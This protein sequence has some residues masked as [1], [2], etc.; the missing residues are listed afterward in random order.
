MRSTSTATT[1]RGD[2]LGDGH[3]RT[4][5]FVVARAS[6]LVA[7]AMLSELCFG[8]CSLEIV[9]N[10]VMRRMGRPAQRPPARPG[11][12]GRKGR[13]ARGAPGRGPGR[14]KTCPA[15]A[16]PLS[17]A[18]GQYFFKTP[19]ERQLSPELLSYPPP[20]LAWAVW[21]H[22]QPYKCS[23]MTAAETNIAKMRVRG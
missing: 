22:S 8:R 15:P 9:S 16:L 7:K 20:G 10:S 12:E 21:C 1:T 13:R 19:P 5:I 18:V 4:R 3:P 6:L 11:F 2:E 23:N 14:H 17:A